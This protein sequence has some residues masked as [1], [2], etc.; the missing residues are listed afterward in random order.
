MCYLRCSGIEY[1]READELTV[2]FLFG[3]LCF[4]NTRWYNGIMSFF[5]CTAG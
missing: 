3:G 4:K 2:C 5:F 1:K